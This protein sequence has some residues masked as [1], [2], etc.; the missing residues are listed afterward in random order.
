LL[1][2]PWAVRGGNTD[3]AFSVLTGTYTVPVDGVYEVTFSGVAYTVAGGALNI[4]SNIL[5]GGVNVVNQFLST[6]YA[7]GENAAIGVSGVF[8]LKA[9]D[10]VQISVQATAG[11]VY[12]SALS[13]AS[14]VTILN[15]KSLF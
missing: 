3:G 5:I 2:G 14:G 7:A 10:Q 15:I 8:S 6:T 1:N 11:F 4:Q 12:G 9:K 13:P